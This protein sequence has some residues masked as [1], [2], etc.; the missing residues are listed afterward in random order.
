MD[1]TLRSGYGWITPDGKCLSVQDPSQITPAILANCPGIKQVLNSTT[2]RD[3]RFY[4]HLFNYP[5]TR[6]YLR[7]SKHQHMLGVE[8]HTIQD[9]HKHE[10]LLLHIASSLTHKGQQLQLH[11]FLSSV[12]E[13][14]NDP[15]RQQ[16]FPST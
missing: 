2:S 14:V 12:P 6:G 8:G 7:V 13:M 3:E 4:L 9:I 1:N 16:I 11:Q 10:S 15:K 5:Y